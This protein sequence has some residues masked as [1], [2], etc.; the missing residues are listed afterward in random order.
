MPSVKLP[1]CTPASIGYL[2][3]AF[4]L[5]ILGTF[6]QSKYWIYSN[7]IQLIADSE[8]LDYPVTFYLPDHMGYNWSIMSPWFD[9]QI[10]TRDFLQENN[11]DFP[12]F[13]QKSLFNRQYVYLYVNELYVPDTYAEAY[14]FNYN[15]MILLHG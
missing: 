1:I 4:Q 8:S 12:T 10:T 15:H 5:A 2:H 14:Q 11:I 7:Y 3:N 6:E 13:I 9:Y